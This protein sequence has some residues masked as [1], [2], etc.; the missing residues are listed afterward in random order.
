MVDTTRA[1]DIRHDGGRT[2]SRAL[3]AG[4]GIVRVTV[5]PGLFNCCRVGERVNRGHVGTASGEEWRVILEQ[6]RSRPHCG[7]ESFQ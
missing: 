1:T 3:S 4:E 5:R 7:C 2:S 6:Q